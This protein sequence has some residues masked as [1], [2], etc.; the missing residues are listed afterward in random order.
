M[1][2]M[3][4]TTLVLLPVMAHAQAG[5]SIEHQPSTSSATEAE[6]TQPAGLAKLAIEAAATKAPAPSAA[7]ATLGSANHAMIREFVQTK[8][9]DDFA[10]AALMKGGTLEYGM[11]NVPTE[12][13]APKVTRAVE[14]SL[15]PQELEEQPAV[16]NVVVHAMVDVNGIPRNVAVTKSGGSV[17][18]R[19]VIEAVSQYRFTPATL[20]NKATWATV[21]I[22]IKIEKP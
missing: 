12:S 16:T 21:S 22:S 11:G 7:I 18:D 3:I 1:R 17:I 19:K 10:D 13:S 14:V 2:R 8:M 6:L 20:D 15:T 5:T 9:T 4:L